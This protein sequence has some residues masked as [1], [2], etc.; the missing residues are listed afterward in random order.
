MSGG[1]RQRACLALAL[2]CEAPLL[3][4]DE[5]TTALDTVTQAAVVQ[6]L[7]E[8]TGAEGSARRPGAPRTEQA[9]LRRGAPCAGTLPGDDVHVDCCNSVAAVPPCVR[10][11]RARPRRPVPAGGC[12]TVAGAVPQGARPSC[13][14]LSPPT[15][16][17]GLGRA[18]DGRRCGSSDTVPQP[19]R[20]NH[21]P[22]SPHVAHPRAGRRARRP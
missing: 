19:I 16:R 14:P 7:R 20:G 8:R 10:R 22:R 1:Q 5:C 17:L 12:V 6:L 2:A 11:A 9:S 15:R 13:L 4:A 18:G 3:V 21:H